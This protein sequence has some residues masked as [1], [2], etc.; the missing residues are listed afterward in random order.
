M[1][2]GRRGRGGGLDCRRFGVGREVG[3]VF[4]SSVFLGVREMGRRGEGG[5][6]RGEGYLEEGFG[7]TRFGAADLEFVFTSA[8]LEGD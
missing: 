3:G 7:A 6:E 2:G 1:W 5:R 8:F 4:C